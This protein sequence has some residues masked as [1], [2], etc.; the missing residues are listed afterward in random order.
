MATVVSLR[1]YR[2][3]AYVARYRLTVRAEFPATGTRQA[4]LQGVGESR[5]QAGPAQAADEAV[6][7]AVRGLSRQLARRWE[8]CMARGKDR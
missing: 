6:N 1:F 2:P 5:S 7:Q 8:A 3:N 4:W